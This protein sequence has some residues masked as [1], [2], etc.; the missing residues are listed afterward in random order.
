MVKEHYNQTWVNLLGACAVTFGNHIF[1]DI[2]K[3][4]VRQTIRKHEMKHVEQ[5]SK[6]G[7]VGFLMIYLM[8]YVIGRLKGKD[9]WGAYKDIPFEIEARAAEKGNYGSTNKISN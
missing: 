7:V 2:D 5:Y 8:W 3:P 4:Y 6:Y 1:Y 9:H